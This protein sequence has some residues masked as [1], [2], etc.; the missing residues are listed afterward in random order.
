MSNEFENKAK[1][2]QEE[3]SAASDNTVSAVAADNCH[4]STV[5]CQ[6]PSAADNCQLSTVNCQL[7]EEDKPIVVVHDYD[8]DSEVEAEEAQGSVISAVL[9]ASGYNAEDHAP[10]APEKL[11]F[12][13]GI[14]N[15]FYHYKIPV[16]VALLAAVMI[17]WLIST[18]ARTEYDLSLVIYSQ[19]ATDNINDYAAHDIGQFFADFAPD[20]DKDGAVEV[21]MQYF[22]L[23]S[24]EYEVSMRA[25]SYY[26]A[27]VDKYHEVMIYFTDKATFDALSQVEDFADYKGMGKWI[28]LAGTSLAEDIEAVLGVSADELGICLVS[29]PTGDFSEEEKAKITQSYDASLEFL[30]RLAAAY[31]DVFSK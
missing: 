25:E 19:S 5:N 15:F 22:N 17:S 27:N 18:S 4:L 20:T 11:G 16:I 29:S 1:S 10:A 3:T 12:F 23:L 31:P 6:L 26:R 13:K 28:A 14:Q 9:K 2:E 7:P 21:N 8:S 24:P 30:G